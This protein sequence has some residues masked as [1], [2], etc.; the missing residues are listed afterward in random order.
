MGMAGG[1]TNQRMA[2][3][4]IG[5]V[6]ILLSPM[7]VR[8]LWYELCGMQHRQGRTGVGRIACGLSSKL[9]ASSRAAVVGRFGDLPVWMRPLADGIVACSRR[10]SCTCI[11]AAVSV[12]LTFMHICRQQRFRLHAHAPGTPTIVHGIYLFVISD[13]SSTVR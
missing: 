1:R 2:G 12:Q 7:L 6:Q 5:H 10:V 8:V 3:P 11:S 13:K 4:V 9:E